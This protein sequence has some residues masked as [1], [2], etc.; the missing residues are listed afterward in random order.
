MVNDESENNFEQQN[1]YAEN[2]SNKSGMFDEGT[3]NVFGFSDDMNL[4]DRII[5]Q[6]ATANQTYQV[7]ERPKHLL[8]FENKDLEQDFLY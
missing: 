3:M 8:S 1:D 2:E 4:D 7:V 5:V 6:N